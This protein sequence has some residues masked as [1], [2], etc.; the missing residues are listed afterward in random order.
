[1]GIA[2]IM[3]FCSDF[4]IN[5]FYGNEYNEASSVFVIHVWAG[6]FVFMGVVFSKY[7]ISENLTKKAFYRTLLGAIV[8]IVGNYFFI[9]IYGI[10]GAAVATLLG[11]FFANYGYD[12]FDKELHSQLKMKTR[13]LF[14]IDVF[15]R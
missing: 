3:T 11:Q 2:T 1:M 9:P 10:Q 7:L 4:I 12:F 13:G 15:K 14:L 8:N 5:L 6:I